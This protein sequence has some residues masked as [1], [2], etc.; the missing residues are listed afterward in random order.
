MSLNAYWEPWAPKPRPITTTSLTDANF[1][2]ALVDAFGMH[3]GA[4]YGE[5][6]LP[7]LRGM[8]AANQDF[9]QLVDAIEKYGTIRVWGEV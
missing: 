2:R 4:E 6:D 5:G 9:Q 1:V 7:I 8:A 3:H